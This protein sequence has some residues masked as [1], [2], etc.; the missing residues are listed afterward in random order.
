MIKFIQILSDVTG[1]LVK[2]LSNKNNF[3]FQKGSALGHMCLRY[4]NVYKKSQMF[5]IQ[6]QS[7]S[8]SFLGN[9]RNHTKRF[10][11]VKNYMFLNI[12][13]TL[14][15][16]LIDYLDDFKK[17]RQNNMCATVNTG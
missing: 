15:S 2:G 5:K 4:L 8:L 17:K 10:T 13:Y 3:H 16:I 1:P 12:A 14:Y 9:V 11:S 6:Q 7:F